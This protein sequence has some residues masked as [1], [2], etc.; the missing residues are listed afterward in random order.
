M[1]R[2][3]FRAVRKIWAKTDML[4]S[5]GVATLTK[6]FMAKLHLLLRILQ[7]VQWFYDSITLKK[8]KKQSSP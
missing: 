2:N 3:M 5:F 8:P 4:A 6:L 1:T 7:N